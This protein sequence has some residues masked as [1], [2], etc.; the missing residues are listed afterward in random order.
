MWTYKLLDVKLQQFTYINTLESVAH[1]FR[2]EKVTRGKDEWGTT[3]LC[4]AK[5]N[6]VALTFT[7]K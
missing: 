1:I 4:T 3:V 6:F 2:L 5:Y 7:R